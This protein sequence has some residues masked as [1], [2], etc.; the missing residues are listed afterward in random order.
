M[1]Q[2]TRQNVF[3]AKRTNL[4]YENRVIIIFTM[5]TCS[6]LLK[7]TCQFLREIEDVARGEVILRVAS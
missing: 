5:Y 1:Y 2:S 6:N 7:K 4:L 3:L